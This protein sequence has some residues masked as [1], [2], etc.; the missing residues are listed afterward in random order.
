[1]RV[2]LGV[3]VV[4]FLS[5]GPA[6]F[7][8]TLDVNRQ[9]RTIEIIVSESVR[10][11][12]DVAIITVGCIAY[13][14]THD[15]AYQANLAIADKVIKA[16]LGTGVAK[17]QIE[18]GSIQLSEANSDDIAN[19]PPA[20]RKARQ[21]KAHQ[22]WRI[23]LATSDAQKL[24]DV[25]VQAGANGVEDVSWDVADSEALEAKARV[26]AMEKA[27]T[28]A[29]EMAKSAGGKLGDLLY[30]SNVV[31]G[32]MG[33]LARNRL[34]TSSA[35]LGSQGNGFPTPAFSLQLF[36]GKVEKQATVRTVFALD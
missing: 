4:F 2:L 3:G 7:S 13:G 30:A 24:I 27:R 10:V 32:I 9:N 22:G 12:P 15:Q 14:Q 18:T 31:N 1:M 25:A 35:S 16:L 34:E 11:D 26:A 19:Q 17:A 5:T 6:A 28:T 36:P 21:F 20:A 23:R 29:A 8:Q 33:L